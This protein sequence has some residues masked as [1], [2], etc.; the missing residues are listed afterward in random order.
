LY[1]AK[2]ATAT[3]STDMD[4]DQSNGYLLEHLIRAHSRST[5]EGQEETQTD[6]WACAFQPT[7]PVIRSGS[8]APKPTPRKSSSIVATCGGNTVCLIDCQLGKVMAK[9]SHMEEEEFMCLAWTTLD[10]DTIEDS[11][12]S[13]DDKDSAIAEAQ[14]QQSNI[15]AA[16]GTPI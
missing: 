6:M 14:T 3:K 8:G 16:A 12:S 15:L 9:Y 10:H 1:L 5:H 7:L 4:I 11:E 2:G 13:K